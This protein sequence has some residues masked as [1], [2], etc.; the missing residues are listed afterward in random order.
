MCI[1]IYI[2]TH[3][4]IYIYICTY[5][6]VYIYVNHNLNPLTPVQAPADLVLAIDHV[7]LE[8]CLRVRQYSASVSLCC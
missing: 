7:P 8:Y 4:H 6:C 3:T 2:Y 1:Y 5:M